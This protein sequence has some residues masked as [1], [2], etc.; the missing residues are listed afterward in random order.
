M[1]GGMVAGVIHD[2]PELS[3]LLQTIMDDTETSSRY[4]LPRGIGYS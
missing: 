2:I 1:S 4:L 3:E